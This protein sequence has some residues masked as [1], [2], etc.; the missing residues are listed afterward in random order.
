MVSQGVG[1]YV[2]A[3][4]VIELGHITCVGSQNVSG[5]DMISVY[6][7]AKRIIVRFHHFSSS[8]SL[9]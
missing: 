9:S 7:K 3:M 4:A 6:E 1:V 8:F 2:P 5:Y